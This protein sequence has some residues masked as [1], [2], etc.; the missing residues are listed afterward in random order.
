MDPAPRISL[1]D[2]ESAGR[3]ALASNA[4]ALCYFASGAGD[5]T[6]LAS[7]TPSF[8]PWRLVPRVL[9]DVASVSTAHTLLGHPTATPFGIAPCAFMRL[10]HPDG[11]AGLARASASA[12]VPYCVS[13]MSTTTLEEVAGA[14]VSP[15]LLFQLYAFDDRATTAA[16]VQRS[17]AAG[18]RALVVTVDRPVLGR[19]DGNLRLGFDLPPH[20]CPANFSVGGVGLSAY[21]AEISGRLTWDDIRWLKSL[22]SLPVVVKGVLTPEDAVH[23]VQVGCAAVWVSTHGGRQLDGVVDAVAVLPSIVRAVRQADA[24]RTNEGGAGATPVKTEIWVDGGVRRGVHVLKALALG[25]DFVWVGRPWVWALA[26]DG[27][28]GVAGALAALRDEVSN[29]LALLGCA[30]GSG[31]G[32]QHVIHERVLMERALADHA[33]NQQK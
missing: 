31:V 18:Y 4:P 7:S 12:G 10:A 17:A 23:A 22:T 15:H 13:T 5:E 28:R 3:I 29:G 1:A 8:S 25:A 19:R 24:E 2:Y 20:L 11:E 32:G 26:A 27:E 6:T 30:P 21:R 9:I 33:V 16:L 14:A